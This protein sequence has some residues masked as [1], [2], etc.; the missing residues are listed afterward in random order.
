MYKPLT[1]SIVSIELR[2]DP[3]WSTILTAM[4]RLKSGF[5]RFKI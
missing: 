3:I 5:E 4:A 2:D 1:I